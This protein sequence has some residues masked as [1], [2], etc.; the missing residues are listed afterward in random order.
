MAGSYFTT[1]FLDIIINHNLRGDPFT[2][3]AALYAQK[4][5]GDPTNTGTA[6]PSNVTTRD[7]ATLSA[8]ASGMTTLTVGMN[9]LSTQRETITHLSLWDAAT[10]GACIAIIEL[11]EPVNCGVGDTL[12]VSSMTV[13]FTSE[14][15]T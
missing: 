9:W 4:H 12:E 1:Y 5:V 10:G 8:A 13:L 7:E 15:S 3:P 2:P 11:A 6:F 14:V